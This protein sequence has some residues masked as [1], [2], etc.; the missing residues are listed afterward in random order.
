MCLITNVCLHFMVRSSVYSS[1]LYSMWGR[2]ARNYGNTRIAQLRKRP[3]WPSSL[4]RYMYVH[5]YACTRTSPP[6]EVAQFSFW[7]GECT[8]RS[9]AHI[10]CRLGCLVFPCLVVLALLSCLG[11]ES[12]TVG[13]CMCFCLFS[14]YMYMY[15]LVWANKVCVTQHLTMHLTNDDTH[16]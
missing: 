4:Q 11:S 1:P 15:I 10:V 12:S 2:V 7:C 3:L 9:A 14:L 13:A 8:P 6:C 5:M 16:K